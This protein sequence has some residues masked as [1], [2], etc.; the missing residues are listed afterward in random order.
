[1]IEI[2]TL[3]TLGALVLAGTALVHT[4][5]TQDG[6]PENDWRYYNGRDH[7]TVEHDLTRLSVR[8][9]NARDVAALRAALLE[10]P[11]VDADAL[12]RSPVSEEGWLWVPLVA[13]LT[14]SQVRRFEATL[15]ADARIVYAEPAIVRTGEPLGLTNRLLVSLKKNVSRGQLESLMAPHGTSIVESIDYVEEGYV[16]ELPRAARRTALGVSTDLMESGLFEWSV[17]DFV[18]ERVSRYTP[19]DP[20]YPSQWHLNSTGQGGAKLTADV[21]APQA[22]DTQK[23][24]TS[25]VV[26]IIDGGVQYNHPDFSGNAVAGYDFLG[27]D[28]TPLPSGSGD[29]H[30]TACAGVAVARHNNGIGVAGIAPFCKLMPIRL[31]GTGMTTAKEASAIAFAKNNGAAIMSNS[32]GP[33]DGTGA[34]YA[35]PANVKSA[36]D[37]AKLNG[38]GGKG[39][40]IFFASGNGNE[41][42]ELD[43]YAKYSGVIAVGASNDQAVRSYYSDYGPSLDCVAP[44]NGGTTSGIWTTDRTGTSGYSTG[45]YT[46]T[47]GGTSSACPLAAGV[48][49]LV[50]SQNPNLTWQQAYNNITS[51]ADKIGTGYVNGFSN[52]YGYGK[53]NARAAVL[54]AGGTPPPPPPT[55]TT[56]TH[57]SINVPLAIPDNNTTGISSTNVVSGLVGTLTEVNV[58]VAITHTYKGDLEVALIHPDGTIVLLHNLS[59]GSTDNIVTTFDTLTAPAQSLA[60][61]N[62]KTPNGTWRLRVRDLAAQ[63]I[64]NLTSW[65]V[66]LTYQ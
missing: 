44:S 22:W 63:D 14:D 36:I 64:G 23:G 51:T 9:E 48:M 37:D 27:N 32:W 17:P 52:N 6:S 45:D 2:R 18:V 34:N 38:R 30:G 31:V 25:I 7:Y 41:S 39:C 12:A 53:V 19:N 46:S 29:N 13:G 50:L 5:S 24:S 1:M 43:G 10:H 60:A 35:L 57:S 28:A 20:N 58:S 15:D 66:Q 26:A 65:S 42:V 33:P 62:A 3:T 55:S 8:F 11:E 56:T 47:F 54:A 61:F 4:A 16:L 49:A 21:D 59:G 40:L